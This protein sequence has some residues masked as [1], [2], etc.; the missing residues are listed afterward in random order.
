MNTFQS[1]YLS[2]CVFFR[3]LSI[4]RYR[5]HLNLCISLA[6]S[7]LIFVAGIEATNIKVSEVFIIIIIIIIII[8]VQTRF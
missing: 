8:I 5:I 6:G 2:L 7:L 1:E 3:S 4:L